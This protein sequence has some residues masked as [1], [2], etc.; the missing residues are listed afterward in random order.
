MT[1]AGTRVNAMGDESIVS[2]IA[3]EI[4]EA[5]KAVVAEVKSLAAEVTEA[6]ES[7]ST[8]CDD[9]AAAKNTGAA[10]PEPAKDS[11]APR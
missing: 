8:L 6:V 9:D 11:D 5:A 3:E 1:G 4:A 7:A 10:S 2:T